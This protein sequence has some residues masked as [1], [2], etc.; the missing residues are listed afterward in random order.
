MKRFLLAL[1]F[2]TIA[3][4]MICASDILAQAPTTPSSNLSFI[5]ID[6]N[7]LRLSFTAGDGAKRIIIARE[8]D[9]VTA[10]PI[11]GVDYVDGDFGDGNEIA[12]GEFVVYE[13]SSS[14]PY[15]YELDHSTTYH[16]RI[17]EFNG[18]NSSTD[19]LTS[20]FLE[21]SQATLTNPTVQ[22]SNIT[23]SNV[24]G[25]SMTLNWTNGNGSDRILIAKEG[26]PVDVEPQ[27]LTNYSDC[28]SC[29]G[30]SFY[31]IGTD[32][33]VLYD[34]S[35]SGD[36]ITN[37]QPGTTYHFA[38]FEYN[39][40]SG[41]V[42]LTSTSSPSIPGTTNSQTTS[43]LPTVNTTLMEF[44]QIDG[45]TMRIENFP[46]TFGNGASRLIV[47]KEG[48]PV[49]GSPTN[50]T[51]YNADND[52]GDG[53]T[54]NSGEFVV[55]SGTN[56]SS[57][58]IY[59]LQP[60]TTYHYK[61]FEYNGTG[62]NTFYLTGLDENNDPVFETSQATLTNPTVQA[63][64]ITF[65][66]VE[67]N[68]MT[69]NWDNGNG[70][71]RLLIIKEGSPVD[72]EPQQLT[73]YSDCSS[74]F[75]NSFYEIGTD[76]YV[77]Y[78]G[79]GS[80]DNITNLQ[81][82]ITYHF[83]LF[84]YNGSAGKLYLTS[85][86]TPNSAAGATNSQATEDL[87]S[88]TVNTTLMEFTQI[89]GNRMRIE[90]FPL[91][92]GNGASRL[93][94]AK[95]GS[96]VTG[97][98]TN[99]T[100][101]NADNDFGDGDTLNSGEFVV[102]SGTNGSSQYIYNLQP[103]TTYHYKVFEYNGTGT[104]TFYLTGLDVN[105]DPVFETSQATL[106]NPTIQ[107]SN[108][109]FSNVEGTSMTVNWD[110]GNGDRRLLIVKEGSPVDV[111]PQQ[112][113]NYSDC[114]S[115]FG[116]SFYEIGTDNYVLY[117]SSGSSDN[118]TN[119]QPGLTYHF[120][121]FEYNGNS[122]KLYLTSSSTPNSA[123]GA[124]NSQ[125]TSTFPTV[126]T[127]L[128]E[129]T[130]VDGSRM[131]IENFPLTFGNG[132]RRLIVVKEGGPVTGSP[133]NG[134]P[135]NADNDF[136][137]GDT[138]NP[139]E[140]VVYSGTNGSS[141]YITNLQP[142]TTYHY[143]VFEYNG[144]G[145]NTF[146]LTG[147]GE[148]ND[149]VF[150]T[151]ESTLGPP[152]V[153]SAAVFFNSKTSSSFNLNWT[154]GDGS[155]RILI[156]REETPVD[157]EP[158]DLNSYSDSSSFG[159]SWTEIGTG[160]YVVYDG[161]GNSDNITNL[162]PGTNYHFELFEYNGSSGKVYLRPGYEFQ[163]QTFGTTPTNQVSNAVFN[164]VTSTSMQVDFER[165]DG[166]HRLVLVK[167]DDPVDATPTDLM[168]YTANNAFANG[169]EIGAG[170]YVVYSDTGEN[171]LLTNLDPSS[172]Y[173]FAFFEYAIS[174]DGNLYLTPGYTASET[175]ASLP[176]Q[177]PSNLQ[178]SS[179]AN[180]SA[181]LSWNAE[182]SVLSG[183][184]YVLN[185]D[186]TT[187]DED[188][189]PTGNVPAGT[190]TVNLTELS[191]GTTYYFFV[192]S[193]CDA[194]QSQW[195]NQLSFT[196]LCDPPIA[197]TQD[198]TVQL[199][200]NGQ[201]TVTPEQVDN[202][203]T[204]NCGISNLSLDITEFDCDNL[205]DNTVTFTITDTDNNTDT[206]TTIVTVEDS[207]APIVITE[208]I[209]VQ[210]DSSGFAS[211]IADDI[212]NGST[213][214][215]GIDT[216]SL[217]V[218]SFTSSDIGP[219]VV[220]L[221]VTDINGNINTG[222]ATVTIEE[223]DTNLIFNGSAEIVPVIGNGWTQ[224]QGNTTGVINNNATG[225][226]GQRIFYANQSPLAEFYQD[227]DLSAFITEIDNG[228][229]SFNFS[230]YVQ[231]FPQTPSD[232]GQAIVEY[233][234]QSGNILDTYDSGLIS[235]VNVWTL[236]EDTRLAP[237][238]TRTVRVRI[239]QDRDSGTN[240]DGYID[241][242]VFEE[243]Q[244]VSPPSP[245]V[246]N[247]FED[248]VVQLDSDGNG[249]LTIAEVDNGTTDDGVLVSVELPQTGMNYTCDDIGLNTVT[250]T[251]IDDEN[252][253]STLDVDFNVI[254]DLA[255]VVNTQDL[256]VE[257]DENGQGF[258]T[259]EMV[260]NGS[261]DNCE[262]A[263]YSIDKMN[264]DCTDIGVNVVT[265][266]V[267]D[268]SGNSSTATAD[269]TV[270]DENPS[271]IW[272]LDADL[273]GFGDENIFLEQCSQPAG[274]V[275]QADDCNDSN[276][277]LYPGAQYFE[278]TG[279]TG[280]VDAVVS[281]VSGAPTDTYT[282][283]V[284]YFDV[285]NEMP[286]FGFPR[287]VVDYNSDGNFNG[288]FDRTI[289]L[290][291]LD[292]GDTDLTDGKTYVGSISPL[293][294]HQNY[295]VIVQSF[296]QGCE[297]LFG[298]FDAPDVLEQPDIEIF[299]SDI[300]FSE[301]NPAVN[302][303]LTVSAVVHNVSDLP[304]EDFF[305]GL[306]SQF[307]DTVYPDIFIDFIPPNSS[308]T[309]D[310]SIT[311]P[312]VDA[313]V[314]MQ[315][316]IDKTD[317][318]SESNELDNRAIRPYVNGDYNVPG[319]IDVVSSVSPTTGFTFTKFFISGT[320]TYSDLAVPLADPSVMGAEVSIFVP[321]LSQTFIGYTN[322]AGNFNIGVPSGSYI[323]P[324]V[325]SYQ[326]SVTDFTLQEEFSGQFTVTEQACLPDISASVSFSPNQVVDNGNPESNLFITIT[327]QGCDDIS[328]STNLSITQSPG[329]TA[330]PTNVSIPPLQAGESQQLSFNNLQ[331]NSVGTYTVSVQADGNNVV[332]N[333]ISE[334]NNFGSDNISIL[335]PK[336]DL[337][338]QSG[339]VGNLYLCQN[340]GQDISFS[341]RN[342]GNI[343]TSNDF[344]T[345]INVKKDG[346]L[347]DTYQE[348]YN[349]NIGVNGFGSVSIP[350]VYDEVANYTFEVNV[351]SLD[352]VDELI[353]SNNTAFRSKNIL[354]CKPDL[355]V[356]LCHDGL[357]VSPEDPG[358]AANVTYSAEIFNTGL[359]QLMILQSYF[360]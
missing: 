164:V 218:S 12:P 56:G 302:S 82:G 72:V 48:G 87:T 178:A 257:I 214:N 339:P 119:L 327:N 298:P 35:G 346:V 256:T 123:A 243:T 334:N 140:F 311:T 110:N 260:D 304:A 37:L 156:A 32:N 114:S 64:N 124:T 104:N 127:T 170:N 325:Y 77:L 158:Q 337:V 100:S 148:N 198:I 244:D 348:V 355:L 324:G 71:R 254:D 7:R 335:P 84:E 278:F 205:G 161:S 252:N 193:D 200:S 232:K 57:Q 175:T 138:L 131:R 159:Q 160:N 172:T 45:N 24:E 122:G 356:S 36:N 258:L 50:G 227:V 305:V 220:T 276:P 136:G 51:S 317:V 150:E 207:T 1:R 267:T 21:G 340:G 320:A 44:T 108:I 142:N 92:F 336:P 10:V 315:V 173:H 202:D 307:D 283:E 270:Q 265:L 120:A 286:A 177:V 25:T 349:E 46:L 4:L 165:G 184:D 241:N 309:V 171:F 96:P 228:S 282:F 306:V 203:S 112:L 59:N 102:Y 109:T 342:V 280:F 216:L 134:T 196:T 201:I 333:E 186:G 79:S 323:A 5:N 352:E 248:I 233:R 253:V 247:V 130:Q 225:Q 251:A 209:T 237:I 213:D 292:S 29:F 289:I 58:Y 312:A 80:S 353:E 210:L 195:S 226:D 76:N 271:N 107:A 38:I 360:K 290:T 281:P 350:N 143:K 69:L 328:Q 133:T 19:Y 55:Y 115:C 268:T 15:V 208:N 52:F 151:S 211:I 129:F 14:F 297:T 261:T 75:G 121:L 113:T 90:N 16:F 180:I 139:G 128:M 284:N 43:T 245:P 224:V 223:F 91:T 229:K 152:T 299:A 345:T 65:S 42:Y 117:D 47:A 167:K 103:N 145:T 111:E 83:A 341:I 206:A 18:S 179:I 86:S 163:E 240:N 125:S 176:C 9:P 182:P 61:V 330:L 314:P 316:S 322:N 89:D 27:Q 74:C 279:N 343:P 101:Y 105:N 168:S 230:F 192:S 242:I 132:S 273:D 331:F 357:I 288:Q 215:C 94:V 191:P 344:T 310:W 354:E 155:R 359:Q 236:V 295:Q 154:N 39:G 20:S 351:D 34:G 347:Q 81:P 246:I 95:E 255:P 2:I 326:G 318:I 153:N 78:D 219:N 285:N 97:S 23:F 291:P 28:S 88:P 116:N 190:N 332:N 63:S 17:F 235:S 313:F 296:I 259:A 33:Y 269:I 183:F 188:T 321:G 49:T 85:S 250:V 329:F 141:Q 308:V 266:T 277:D 146:Y 217:D 40:S 162:E 263:S 287:A 222:Q 53:D 197:L 31:E 144:S 66:N 319:S 187:P 358:S 13:G 189:I 199:D 234:D 238:G 262:I 272:Y 118:I 338:L 221:T 22:A 231:S 185:T 274:Y 204:A 293:E 157:V 249:T 41:E 275:A 73:N 62:T 68:S 264:F 3:F 99:G 301:N 303:Q 6:G 300:S 54:L 294:V 70:D 169:D 181:T 26:S 147:L 137:D 166:S 239:I 98:P 194:N 8:D 126:N 11:D 60:N 174:A 135:Y 93:I 30:N 149:P 67:D 212:D 106:A